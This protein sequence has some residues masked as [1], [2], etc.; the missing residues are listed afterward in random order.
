MPA[1]LAY[2]P[3]RDW[4]LIAYDDVSMVLARRAAFP[5]ET[6]ERMECKE[7]VPDG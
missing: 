7:K 3:R 4:A 1:S 2:W 6:V 5:R